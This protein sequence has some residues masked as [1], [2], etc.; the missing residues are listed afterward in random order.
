MS[1]KCKVCKSEIDNSSGYYYYE[2]EVYCVECWGK[3][4]IKDKQKRYWNR[5]EQ[6]L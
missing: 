6:K 5:F 4:F 3:K 1:R 2:G